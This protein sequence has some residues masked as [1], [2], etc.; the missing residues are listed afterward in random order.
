MHDPGQF[1]VRSELHAGASLR[2]VGRQI[3]WVALYTDAHSAGQNNVQSDRARDIDADAVPTA[4]S[5]AIV[6][7]TERDTDCKQTD[8][9]EH[10]NTKIRSV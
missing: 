8:E 9:N 6:C 7:R 3:A 2:A 4:Q 5:E 10:T 1:E